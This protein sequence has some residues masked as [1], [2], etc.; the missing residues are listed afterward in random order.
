[1]P[2]RDTDIPRDLRQIV[3][4]AEETGR[5]LLLDLHPPA[6]WH[7]CLECNERLHAQTVIHHRGDLR[8]VKYSCTCGVLWLWD[9]EADELYYR[10][11][12]EVETFESLDE[13]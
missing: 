9:A 13:E 7:D 4:S 2:G 5:G 1:M 11:E 8:A 12:A 3:D 6:A 10:G